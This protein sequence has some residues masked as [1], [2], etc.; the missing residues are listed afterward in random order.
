[1]RRALVTAIFA[2]V[3]PGAPAIAQIAPSGQECGEVTVA[4]MNWPS[5]EILA[6]LDRIILE[7][8][9]GC[10]VS[11]VDAETLPAIDTMI[12]GGTPD[13]I[14]EAWINSA[15]DKIDTAVMQRRLHYLAPALVDGAVEGWWV[16]QYIVEANPEIETIAD[17]LARPD[18]FPSPELEGSAAIHTCP[19]GWICE[20][21]TAHL[22]EA[23]DAE[24]K[25]FQ[26]VPAASG[27]D[28]EASIAQAFE[29]RTGWLGYYWAPNPT[30]ARHPMVKL[31][32]DAPYDEELW[33]DCMTVAECDTP[34]ITAWP[35]SEVYTLAT[36]RFVRRAG[37]AVGYL[38][39]RAWGN[40]VVNALLA[41]QAE[42]DASAEDTARHFLASRADVWNTW[43]TPENAV[44]LEDAITDAPEPQ[45]T[46]P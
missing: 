10:S 2:I 4:R 40:D 9:F 44:R 39:E 21:A 18:L 43:L 3:L 14:P 19:R 30:L 38:R 28:L 15:R 33:N 35:R 1:M 12:A 31:G 8:V 46:R 22:F 5:A 42:N 23:Y 6:E 29:N 27:E 17:A 45:Q 16:P 41:W 37:G 26:L 25:G 7:T 24:A 20:I 34:R 11:L 13:V 32:F 36:D